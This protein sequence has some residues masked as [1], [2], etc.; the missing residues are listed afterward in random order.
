MS[1]NFKKWKNNTGFTL[2]EIIVAMGV[3]ISVLTSALVLITLSVNSTKTTR[4][5]I[6][7]IGLSQEGLEIV[8]NI[9]DNNW[10]ARRRTALNW[11]Q[12]LDPG[13]YR[14]QYNSSGLLAFSTMSLRL[15]SGFYQYD[16]GNN[17]LFYRKIT[18]EHIGNNQIRVI[19]EI[20]W[21]ERGR[22]QI[23]SAETRLYNWLEEI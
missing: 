8:R 16:S 12:D 21:N 18:I 1:L 19:S 22:N 11:K 23:I 4:S 2:L 9:R 10:L 14:V 3:I 20:T 7:A 15:N 6:I 17:T 13:N 5:K